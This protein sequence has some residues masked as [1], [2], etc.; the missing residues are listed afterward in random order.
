MATPLHQRCAAAAYPR[1]LAAVLTADEAAH[2]T[3]LYFDRIRSGYI[4]RYMMTYCACALDPC[5]CS[6]RGDAE[7]RE[8]R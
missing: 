4:Q 1:S 7:A 5:T 2:L 3:R 8:L 6:N